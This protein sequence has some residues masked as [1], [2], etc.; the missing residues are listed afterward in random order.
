MV[1]DVKKEF[2]SHTVV[3]VQLCSEYAFQLMDL[4]A[5]PRMDDY[6]STASYDLLRIDIAAAGTVHLAHI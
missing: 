4:R 6:T 5:P 1:N 3:Q 2:L